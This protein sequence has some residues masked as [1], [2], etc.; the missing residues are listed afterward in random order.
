MPNKYR[1]VAVRH[2]SVYLRLKCRCC[3]N[4]DT[5]H[6][7]FRSIYRF[8]C[9]RYTGQTADKILALVTVSQ[10]ALGADVFDAAARILREQH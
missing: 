2:R 10:N 9:N 7:Q 8:A 6:F 5:V 3:L 1:T 4:K